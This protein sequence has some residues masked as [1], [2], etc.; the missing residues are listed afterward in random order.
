[1]IVVVLEIRRRGRPRALTEFAPVLLVQLYFVFLSGGFDAF[2]GGVPF[3]VGYALHLLEAG[4]CIAYVSSVMDRFLTLLR[5]GEFF[6]AD[7][8]AA[9][10]GDLGHCS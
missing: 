8:M 9:G 7:L 5:E 1:M 6:I 3:G 2:P 10:F 4:D